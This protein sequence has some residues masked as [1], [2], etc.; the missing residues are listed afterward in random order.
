MEIK[1][2]NFFFLLLIPNLIFLNEYKFKKK[3]NYYIYIYQLQY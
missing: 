3:I 1:I 2:F